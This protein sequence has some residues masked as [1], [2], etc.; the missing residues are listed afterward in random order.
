LHATPIVAIDYDVGETVAWPRYVD[1]IAA[2]YRLIP[3]GARAS[4]VV[5]TRNYGEAGAIERY[6]PELGLPQAYSGHNA[7]WLW[8]PPPPRTTTVVAVGLPPGLL[9]RMFRSVAPAGRL[10]NGLGI[11]D[12]EQHVRLWIASGPAESWSRLWPQLRRYG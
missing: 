1:Q 4:A 12:D 7:F 11:S 9:A 5:L 2:A 10:D 6:G 8:G 3:A